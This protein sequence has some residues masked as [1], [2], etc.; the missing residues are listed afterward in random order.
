MTLSGALTQGFLFY[1]NDHFFPSALE[2]LSCWNKFDLPQSF[3]TQMFLVAFYLHDVQRL[4]DRLVNVFKP[5]HRDENCLSMTKQFLKWFLYHFV[6]TEVIEQ[7]N[8]GLQRFKWPK[9]ELFAGPAGSSTSSSSSSKFSL[10]DFM[11]C[12]V[13]A[14]K[15]AQVLIS[16]NG[17]SSGEKGKHTLSKLFLHYITGFPPLLWKDLFAKSKTI[18]YFIKY[19]D[20]EDLSLAF[21]KFR[22]INPGNA[23]FQHFINKVARKFREPIVPSETLEQL[24]TSE[25]GNEDE[26]FSRFFRE[27]I[28]TGNAQNDVDMT[29]VYHLTAKWMKHS[30]KVIK[31]PLPPRNAQLITLL[32]C[33]SFAKRLLIHKDTSMGRGVIAQVGTGEGKSL[34]IAFMAIYCVKVLRKSVHILENNL[35]LLEKDFRDLE[36]LFREFDIISRGGNSSFNQPELSKT[37]LEALNTKDCRHEFA[38]FGVT[39][40]L[41]RNMERYYQDCM[42]KAA[43]EQQENVFPFEN[44]V[45]IV[46][47]VDDLIVDS[48]PNNFSVAPDNEEA[49]F[50]AAINHLKTNQPDNM[51]NWDSFIWVLARNSYLASLALQEGVHYRAEGSNLYMIGPGGNL[52]KAYDYRLECKK[53]HPRLKSNYYC[54]SIPYMF[55]QYECLAGFS[56]SIGAQEYLWDQFKTW[57]FYTPSFLNT[58]KGVSKV[59]P[60]LMDD[61][62]RKGF[63]C[64]HILST[65]EKQ[66]QK[67]VEIAARMYIKVPVLIIA[68]SALEAYALE[69]RLVAYL[70]V[71]HNEDERELKDGDNPKDFVQTFLQFKKDLTITTE[72]RPSTTPDKDNWGRIVHEA[73]A[74]CSDRYRIT[75]TDPFGGRG[76]DFDVNDEKIEAHHGFA[77]IMTSIPISEREWIQWKGRTSRRDNRGQYTVVL[78]EEDETIRTAPHVLKNQD[79][80]DIGSPRYTEKV[81]EQIIEIRNIHES[82]KLKEADAEISIGRRLNKLCDEFYRIYEGMNE[83][84]WTT[85]QEQ[86]ELRNLLTSV[87]K[88]HTDI[89]DAFR[90]LELNEALTFPQSDRQYFG[91]DSDDE[92]GVSDSQEADDINRSDDIFGNIDDNVTLSSISYDYIENNNQRSARIRQPPRPQN[93]RVNPPQTNTPLSPGSVVSSR[94]GRT[95]MNRPESGNEPHDELHNYYPQYEDD[96]LVTEYDLQSSS[97]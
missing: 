12:A 14:A 91:P 33:A 19:V 5:L 62:E 61:P 13:H 3:V 85:S 55:S 26:S 68:A 41:R 53:T 45:L 79:P 31:T 89:D 49:E 43:E 46:D 7:E 94:E 75:V 4:K 66:F 25:S 87:F 60:S 21:S 28:E 9:G 40:C 24:T 95:T 11:E 32:T 27:L 44:T 29:L 65:R 10:D 57:S 93:Q 39:Y 86:V 81:I 16:G 92:D 36:P 38:T 69:R 76:H 84:T 74:R 77:L 64:V 2:A 30:R 63:P 58:C 54:Q 15:A 80:A 83:N 67:I 20:R 6:L 97:G 17:E 82:R 23:K 73:T 42:M 50:A 47:E 72:D 37:T 88:S 34:I 78:S 18:A 1:D 35:G 22:E 70:C 96:V 59:P 71:K 48:N 52:I 8:N 51:F 56:G 90:K